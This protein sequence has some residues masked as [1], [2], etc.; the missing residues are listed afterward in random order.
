[1]QIVALERAEPAFISDT[2]MT[3]F[4]SA[5]H[6]MSEIRAVLWYVASCQFRTSTP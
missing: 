2:G 1:M 3:N 6:S 4:R 5:I